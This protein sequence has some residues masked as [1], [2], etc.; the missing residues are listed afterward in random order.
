MTPRG[1]IGREQAGSPAVN[2]TGFLGVVLLKLGPSSRAAHA[3]I[4]H[5]PRRCPPSSTRRTGPRRSPLLLVRATPPVRAVGRQLGSQ[6]GSGRAASP[7]R[8]GARVALEQ[9]QED[10]TAATRGRQRRM[11]APPRRDA[12]AARRPS[13]CPSGRRLV[14]APRR[15]RARAR[16]RR[17]LR[18]PAREEGRRHAD[19]CLGGRL[20]IVTSAPCSATSQ[21][22]GWHCSATASAGHSPPRAKR[23]SMGG[24]WRCMNLRDQRPVARPWLRRWRSRSSCCS[25][26]SRCCWRSPGSKPAASMTAAATRI[27]APAS[28]ASA[29]AS[30]GRASTWRRRP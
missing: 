27:G 13:G 3:R 10:L 20:P 26:R 23:S 21:S 12:S 18:S 29:T 22:N 24:T 5:L 1:P 19:A 15:H 11:A 7:D 9:P 14:A 8:F 4:C 16:L 2:R 25:S 17:G 30:P 6:P 28:R